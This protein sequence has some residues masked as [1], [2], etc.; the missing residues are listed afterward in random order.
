MS[1]TKME[2]E[3]M[4]CCTFESCGMLK[5]KKGLIIGIANENSIAWG[6]ANAMRNE[7]A[8]I[9]VTYLN[10]KAEK[11]VRPLAEKI[12]SPIVMPVNVN[13]EGELEALFAEIEKKW[14][15]LDFILH[16]IAFAR[17]E[18]LHGRV[19]DCSKD[20]FKEAMDIS[21]HSFIRMAKLAE[22][23]MK[24]G[25]C[26]L[27]TTYYG[28]Q[29]YI[30]NYNIMGPVK[31]ALESSVEYLAAELGPKKIRV[32][33]ISPGPIMTRAASGI[34]KFDDLLQKAANKAPMRELVDIHDVG[35]MA[36]FLVSDRA[37]HISG[38]IEFIDSGYH[39]VG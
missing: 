36:T 4:T 22:P 28:G 8:E 38:N 19:V 6:C 11:Y 3:K 20:G 14:G 27:T 31:A 33:A 32:N 23:L 15:K 21:V 12:D 1:I 29:Q 35:N 16:S 37:C 24:D 2:R 30:E 34:G 26:M 10:E 7:G 39:I 13:N 17:M 9:A 5:G 18:D 25:G